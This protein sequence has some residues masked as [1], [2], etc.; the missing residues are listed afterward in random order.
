M[1]KNIYREKNVH[2]RSME[3]RILESLKSSNFD[4]VSV[5]LLN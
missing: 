5:I 2:L 3:L 1:E 4:L